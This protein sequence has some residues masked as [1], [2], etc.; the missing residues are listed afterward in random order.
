MANRHEGVPLYARYE[1]AQEEQQL[2]MYETKQATYVIRVLPSIF[3]LTSCHANSQLTIPKSFDKF[4]VEKKLSAAEVLLTTET[5]AIR[6]LLLFNDTL[7]LLENSPNT[8]LYLFSTFN[9]NTKRFV[10]PV[11]R[12]GRRKGGSPGIYLFWHC[13]K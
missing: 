5:Q 2:L 7:L 8:A 4:P 13:G 10:H 6:R 3:L 11:V 12:S 1:N 9:L